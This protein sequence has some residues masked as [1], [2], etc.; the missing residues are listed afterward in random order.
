MSGH[1]L[2]PAA[3][4]TAPAFAPAAPASGIPLGPM[5]TRAASLAR[6]GVD[7]RAAA[8]RALSAGAGNGNVARA[9]QRSILSDIHEFKYGIEIDLP[10]ASTEEKLAEIRRLQGKG[11][12]LGI[13]EVWESIPDLA[14]VAKANAKLFLSCARGDPGLLELE[15]FDSVRTAF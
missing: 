10:V 9:V 12:G 1:E 4:E 13:R 8:V 15:A 7:Q 14:E 11:N 6:M 5:P 2:E 3:P